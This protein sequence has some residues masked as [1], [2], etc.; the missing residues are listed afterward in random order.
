MYS[1]QLKFSLERS[2]RRFCFQK[3]AST[4]AKNIEGIEPLMLEWEI[5]TEQALFGT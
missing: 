4:V 1:R 3:Y 5:P 2:I